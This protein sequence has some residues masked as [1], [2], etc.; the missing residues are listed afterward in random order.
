[1]RFCTSNQKYRLGRSPTTTLAIGEESI[2][3]GGASPQPT[4]VTPFASVFA[5]TLPKKRQVLFFSAKRQYT[6]AMPPF[7]DAADSA[8]REPIAK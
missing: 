4:P 6:A 5:A 2:R 8:N 1:M 7:P 3:F